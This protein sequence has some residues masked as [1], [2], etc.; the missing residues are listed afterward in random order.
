MK[1]CEDSGVYLNATLR[2][3]DN[4]MDSMTV[5]EEGGRMLVGML[6]L[7][8]HRLLRVYIQTYQHIRT[9]EESAL[10]K[11]MYNEQRQMNG[12]ARMA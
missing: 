11:C 6:F 9:T 2:F 10:R 7:E 8:D 3:G 1:E 12:S 4:C 5:S